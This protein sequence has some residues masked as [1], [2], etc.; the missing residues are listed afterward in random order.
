MELPRITPNFVTDYQPPGSNLYRYQSDSG[1]ETR[2][3]STCEDV[4]ASFLVRYQ[5]L[6]NAQ[7]CQ[8]IEWFSEVRLSPKSRFSLESFAIPRSHP[9]W[10]R[11]DTFKCIETSWLWADSIDEALWLATDPSSWDIPQCGF[12][13]LSFRV[14]EVIDV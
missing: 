9:F 2:V 10:R 3:A 6:D 7:L 12:G 1:V 5:G 11:V 4:N 8:F 13:D 14:E